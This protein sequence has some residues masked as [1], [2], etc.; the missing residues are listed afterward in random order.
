M[1]AALIPKRNA[2]LNDLPTGIDRE[3][4]G[5]IS[6]IFLYE[7]AIKRFAQCDINLVVG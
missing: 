5:S 6:A 7:S 2:F 3:R 1:L 4:L